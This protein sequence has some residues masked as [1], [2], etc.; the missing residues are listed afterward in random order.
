MTD[1]GRG[2]PGVGRQHPPEV[3]RGRSPSSRAATSPRPS[4]PARLVSVLAAAGRQAEA[5]AVFRTVRDRRVPTP[6]P[7]APPP[8]PRPGRPC[9]RRVVSRRQRSAAARRAVP[10]PVPVPARAG[11][12][13][14]ASGPGLCPA[15]RRVG[16]QA[17]AP[18]DECAAPVGFGGGLFLQEAGLADPGFSLDQDEPRAWGRHS[19]DVAVGGGRRGPRRF[20]HRRAPGVARRRAQPSR[21]GAGPSPPT[22]PILPAAAPS[23]VCSSRRSRSSAG[24]RRGGR[25]YSSSTTSSGPTP[26]RWTRSVT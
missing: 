10:R 1:L 11:G 19:V 5:L 13:P 7:A 6:P 2:R 18:D 24:C 4:S 9:S 14:P 23:S 15:P 12:R 16:L 26:P 22:T 3:R 21:G 25:S 8:V 17:M 20:A